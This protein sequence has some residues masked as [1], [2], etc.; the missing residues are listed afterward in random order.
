MGSRAGGAGGDI[1]LA[2]VETSV[3][4]LLRAYRNALKCAGDMPLLGR[5]KVEGGH[6]WGSGPFTRLY[7]ELHV[8]RLIDA[9]RAC[10]TIERLGTPAAE[11]E[12]LVALEAE[13]REQVKPLLRWWRIRAVLARLPPVAAAVP[14]LSAASV[15]PLEEDVSGEA[16]VEAALVLVGVALALWLVV[17]WPSVRL[18]FRVKRAILAGGRDVRHPLRKERDELS[19][20]GFAEPHGGDDIDPDILTSGFWR[21]LFRRAA[22]RTPQRRRAF[23]TTNAYELEDRVFALLGRRKRVE[24]PLD[25]LLG[26]APYLTFAIAAL[27]TFALVDLVVSGFAAGSRWVLLPVLLLIA[28]LPLQ[29]VAQMVQNHRKRWH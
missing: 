1:V 12:P 20:Y 21:E 27:A 8:R 24:A 2:D 6:R 28:L 14:I 17:V 15:W 3:D 29:V 4:E 16:V 26:L 22:G 19:W 10:L 7:L 18:G 5:C 9:I 25:M 11:R 23:P 13:L